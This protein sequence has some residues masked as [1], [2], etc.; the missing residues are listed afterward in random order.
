VPDASD[1]QRVDFAP[2]TQIH[3]RPVHTGK[4]F[5]FV[6]PLHRLFRGAW[7]KATYELGAEAKLLVDGKQLAGPVKVAIEREEGSSWQHV[8]TVPAEVNDAGTRATATFRF[9][10]RVDGSAAAGRLTKAEWDRAEAKPGEALGVRVEA[11]GRDGQRIVYEVEREERGHWVRVAHWEGRIE[12]GK[13]ESRYEVPVAGHDV[14]RGGAL[15][16]AAFE[17]G[18]TFA[19]AGETAWTVVRA[20]GLD[21]AA[22]RFEMQREVAEGRWET[23]A[24]AAATVKSGTARAAL[25]LGLEHG[26]AGRPEPSL[27]SA[28]FEGELRVESGAGLVAHARGMDGHVLEFALEVAGV[29]GGWREVRRTQAVV[30]GG[31]ARATIALPP[32]AVAT[33]ERP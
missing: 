16:S 23:V 11:E 33:R 18:D 22:L 5:V 3:S 1:R 13:A 28:G 15:V 10:S 8:A 14:P 19:A 2:A 12:K 4:E 29:D 27:L 20:T 21:G 25:P 24:S 26:T 7:D 6:L 31:A 17:D 9:P 30:R 32:P